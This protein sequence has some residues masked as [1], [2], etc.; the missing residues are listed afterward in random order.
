MTTKSIQKEI[1]AAFN[2]VFTHHLYLIRRGLLKAFKRLAPQMEGKLMD[3]GCG[4]KPYRTLFN[5]DE[6]IGV[7]Y[8]GDGP[9]YDKGFA[10]VFYDGHT[11]PF[12]DGHFDSVFSSEV[13]EHIFNLPEILP[14]LNRVMK[15]GGKILVSCPF[16]LGEHEAPA[17]FARYTSFAMRHLFE[18]NGFEVIELVKTG[19][20]VEAVMQLRMVYWDLYLLKPIKRIPIV[21]S[22][23]RK[24][25]FG[26]GNIWTMF[27]SA[28]LPKSDLLY[29][30]NVVLAKKK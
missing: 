9:T 3:L 14:E 10:D 2:P 17:D 1:S 4:L 21:R 24:T 13:F 30:N 22:A 15:P 25:V 19:T 23:I 12:Q 18:T 28:L 16:A 11:L 5:V 8:H 7:E 6:Y 20:Y 26:I 27:L 29:M